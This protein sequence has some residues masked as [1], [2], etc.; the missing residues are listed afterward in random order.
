MPHGC[1]WILY[2]FRWAILS[3]CVARPLST[4][5]GVIDKRKSTMIEETLTCYTCI[6][7]SD[8]LTCNQYAIDRPC[9]PDLDFCQ[10][11]HIMDSTGSSVIVNKKCANKS[12]CHSSTV[13]CLHI[14]TQMVCVSC[15]DGMY[16]NMT[17]P[18]NQTN[19]VVTISRK[20]HMTSPK[21]SE[22]TASGVPKYTISHLY[23]ILMLLISFLCC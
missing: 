8:N 19:A 11:L 20:G 4:D 3:G 21:D 14:D 22:T 9:A 6:N 7:V 13:G 1:P 12:E 18:T 5:L 2:L 16:C 17:V 15:C 23:I 10:T